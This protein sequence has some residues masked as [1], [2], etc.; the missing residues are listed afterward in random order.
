MTRL[1]TLAR[2]GSLLF[3]F[4]FPPLSDSLAAFGRA[5]QGRSFRCLLWFLMVKE[6]W[7]GA[8]LLTSNLQSMSPP[9]LP[10]LFFKRVQK[11][12]I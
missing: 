1:E 4:L 7:E 5:P 9:G 2:H 10:E 8:K 11:K 3:F 12:E 6:Q